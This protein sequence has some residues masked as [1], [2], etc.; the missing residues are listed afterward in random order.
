MEQLKASKHLSLDMGLESYYTTQEGYKEPV[1]Q[2]YRKVE[3]K[4]NK[5]DRI[6]SGKKHKRDK[7]DKTKPSKRYL[8]YQLK[9]NKHKEKVAN[10]RD[11]FVFKKVKDLRDNCDYIG[12][13]ELETKKMIECQKY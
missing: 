8:K 5:L 6:G 11:D 3:R 2:F 7:D 12:I 4:L 1:P 9:I 10:K 13:E